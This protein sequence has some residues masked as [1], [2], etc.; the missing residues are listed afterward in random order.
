[1]PSTCPSCSAKNLEGADQCAHCGAD[2]RSADLLKKSSPGVERSLMELPL[3][4]LGLASI[5]SVAPDTTVDEAMQTLLRQKLDILAVVEDG[6]LVGLFSVRDI[7]MRVGLDFAARLARPVRD[8][9]TE[10]PET[11]PP[12]APINYAI[13]KMAVGGYRHV[14]VV[15]DG[16]KLLG[17]VSTR[18]VI[19]YLAKQTRA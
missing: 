3:T 11:L 16:G 13:N 19:R 8:F 15:E 7:M 18:D 17:V 2:L 5:H 1:M 9:M 10:N 12:E 14:P 4:A 6:K